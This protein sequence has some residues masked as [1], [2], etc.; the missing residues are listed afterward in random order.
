[1][2]LA[3]HISSTDG[4]SFSTRR[5]RS[6]IRVGLLMVALVA[7]MAQASAWAQGQPDDDG[8]QS[9][10]YFNYAPDGPPVPATGGGGGTCPNP[11]TINFEEA[12]LNAG[13]F[14]TTQIPGVTVST[15]NTSPAG[16]RAMIFNSNC[17]QGGGSPA[18]SGGDHDLR[19]PG[20]GSGNNSARGQILIISEDNDQ[21]D[22]DDNAQGGTL[23]FVFDD[24]VDLL[25]V[26]MLDMDDGSISAKL[27]AYNEG[28]SLIIGERSV[29]ALGNNS[30]QSVGFNRPGTKTLKVILNSSGAVPSIKY[31]PPPPVDLKCEP[32][33]GVSGEYG[34]TNITT[35]HVCDPLNLPA[36]E[37]GRAGEVLRY[38]L[39]F[40]NEAASVTATGLTF[41]VYFPGDADGDGDVDLNFD[42]ANGASC[43]PG[44]SS[45]NFSNPTPGTWGSV[46]FNLN[47]LAAGSD[48]DLE[49][50][51]EVQASPPPSR[52][53]SNLFAEVFSMDQT[54]D[55]SMPGNTG[56]N[57]PV[58]TGEDDE[59]GLVTVLPVELI[60]FESELD[61]RD[62]LL[63]WETASETNNAG[64]EVQHRYVDV[65]EADKTS[66]VFESLGFVEGHGTT[67]E[68]QRYTFR[69]DDLTP[70][71]HVFRL[72]QVDFDGAFEYSPQIEVSVGMPE[73]FLV[74]K[75]Y[76]NPFNPQASLSFGVKQEQEVR[77]ELFNMLGQRVK[78]L[79]AGRPAAGTTKTIQIDGSD[80]RS[81]VYVLRVQGERF[82]DT[83]TITLVK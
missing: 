39:T 77:V 60:S 38:N 53:E 52:T 64:F 49:F 12:G 14:V 76:P 62:A 24:P 9:N 74:S 45:T 51:L 81:G 41:K 40:T 43:S 83:Q 3:T 47:S 1:M 79:F 46:T 63:V 58:L 16:R 23:V 7:W 26:R 27:R 66:A 65:D 21:N 59:C 25:R 32:G 78:V 20:S 19:T 17:G 35:G 70:G 6:V 30:Y 29:S 54:D 36:C 10:P 72:K 2:K 11:V 75:V 42:T 4:P 61:G 69:V 34:Y 31:C 80:L 68:A 56:N 82:V 13:T 8:N 73:S 33:P 44:C 50:H 57:P 55:D 18:C 48:V 22:P 37:P 28:G 5:F 71:R 67:L 15:E